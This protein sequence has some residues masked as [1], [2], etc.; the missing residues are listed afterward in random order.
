MWTD[1]LKYLAFKLSLGTDVAAMVK[2]NEETWR[3]MNPSYGF[4]D[5]AANLQGLYST[6]LGQ[7]QLMARMQS[8]KAPHHS[9]LQHVQYL[10]YLKGE[11][12]T[13]NCMVTDMF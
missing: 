11:I 12:G 9:W 6:H 3:A 1:H 8:P 7:D 2:I 5:L 4:A 13:S 10:K